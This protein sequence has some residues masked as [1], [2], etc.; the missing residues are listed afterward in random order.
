M[1]VEL[2]AELY[3]ELWPNDRIEALIK[4]L[5]ESYGQLKNRIKPEPRY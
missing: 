4:R 5:H 1:D 2:G 3:V